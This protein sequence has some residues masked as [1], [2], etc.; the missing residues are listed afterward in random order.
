[1]LVAG[2]IAGLIALAIIL[3]LVGA[4]SGNGIVHD[5]H[6]AANFFAGAFTSMFRISSARLSLLVNWGIAA[7]VYLAAGALIARMI[8][9]AG[10][11]SALG[12]RHAA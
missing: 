9:W 5:I 12:R 4:N 10:S 8:A 6:V 7:C 2:L 1:M 11:G 3:R